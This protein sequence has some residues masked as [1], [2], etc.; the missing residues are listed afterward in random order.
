MSASRKRIGIIGYGYIGAYVYEQLTSR[1]EPGL[2]VAFVYNRSR[3]KTAKLP[4]GIF[5]EKLEDFASRGADLIVE[6]AHP[7]ITCE[8][9]TAFLA[10]TD[11]LPLSLTALADA[12]VE[13]QLLAAA[14]QHG[15]CLYIPHGAVV[16]M[17]ALEEGR[18]IWEEVRMVMKK[19]PRTLDFSASPR[20]KAEEIR[21]E[22]LLYEGPTRGICP[23]FPRNV[24]SHAA[25]ALGGVGFDRTQSV[26]IADPKLEVSV[27]EIEMRGQGVEVKVQRSNPMKG[28]SGV[29][30]LVS[31]L[32]SICRAK[33]LKG[34]MQLC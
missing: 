8:Y 14:S 27:I 10:A 11:Y 21:Q 19:P 26:L 5:L 13:K 28:V 23:L 32:A 18:Q 24:N 30:T 3:E 34:G 7:T 15:T 16:G 25:V 17:D 31:T 1:P 4:P 29:F 6:L 20:W 33:G 2:E 12:Q 9:G 22:T